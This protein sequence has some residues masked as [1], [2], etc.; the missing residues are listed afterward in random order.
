MKKITPTA[1]AIRFKGFTD[2]WEQR[3]LG[4]IADRVIEK[5][6]SLVEHETFTNSAEFG[7]VSQ[8]D[9]F[10]HGI[11]NEENIGNYYIV[12]PDDFVYNPRISVTA[13]VGPINRN[14]LGRNGVMSPLY[15][16]F[17]P[18]DIDNSYLEYYFK[19]D[20]WHSFMRF[21]GDTGARS[22]RFSI[23]T[24][25]FYEMPISMPKLEEQNA[26]GRFLRNLS[27]L[28]VLHRR[29]LDQQEKLKKY[30]LQNMFPAKGEKVPKI[31]LKGFVG[32]WERKKLGELSKRNIVGL[33]TSVT[34]YYR[35]KGVPILRNLNIKEN[36]LDDRDLLYLDKE[37]ANSQTGKQIHTGDVL[38]VHTGYIG[39]SCLVPKKYNNCLTFTTLVTT[40]NEKKLLGKFL[41]YYLNSPLG[42]ISIQ[43]VT[44]QGGRQNL[45]TND[46]IKVEIPYPTV[47]E[48]TEICKILDIFDKLIIAHQHKLV[49]LETLKK[50][51][52]QNM[53]I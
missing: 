14:K 4:E 12:H 41:S 34:P 13:P 21:N 5:N 2:P 51:M 3:K 10:D 17:R 46:F 32:D 27:E 16:V 6:L 42:M 11:T 31:R 38:T 45:N 30:F 8:M 25:L 40:T 44:T 37:Y 48:Q 52:L 43:A 53:F 35:D 18:H 24:E 36:Y 39:I 28:I 26:I 49:E 15:T 22:D 19:A 20:G 9:F 29:K 47:E 1:P 23:K 50:Y 7:I 33:A